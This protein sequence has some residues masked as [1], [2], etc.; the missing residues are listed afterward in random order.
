MI[1]ATVM[2]TASSNCFMQTLTNA[3][4]NNSNIKG[5]LN[6]STYF[7]QRGSSSLTENS[8]GPVNCRLSSGSLPQRPDLRSTLSLAATSSAPSHD[9]S[10]VDNH[11]VS[12]PP[13]PP[14]SCEP[15]LPSSISGSVS[16]LFLSYLL[17]TLYFILNSKSRTL[18]FFGS[19]P[20]CL[21]RG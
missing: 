14:E 18:H 12:S 16:F 5:F 17:F 15:M 8:L 9:A 13:F 10:P 3:D 1:I 19:K 6:C 4:P 7:F 20:R 11:I 21:S 2:L